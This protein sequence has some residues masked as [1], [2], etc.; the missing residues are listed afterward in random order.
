MNYKVNASI[1]SPASSKEEYFT[2]RGSRQEKYL[3]GISHMDGS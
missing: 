2:G 3:Q 1:E